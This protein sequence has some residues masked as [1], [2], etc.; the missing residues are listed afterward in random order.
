MRDSQISTTAS[1]STILCGGAEPKLAAFAGDVGGG[2]K[3]RWK[4]A[5]AVNDST[6]SLLVLVV[7]YPWTFDVMLYG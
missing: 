7:A 6:S 4:T 5:P 1:V 3:E 2:G